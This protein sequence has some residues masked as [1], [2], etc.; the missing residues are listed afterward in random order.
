MNSRKLGP[1]PRPPA[2]GPTGEQARVASAA[3]AARLVD[4]ALEA[5]SETG[6]PLTREIA[7]WVVQAVV[8]DPLRGIYV[9]AEHPGP[10]GE[11]RGLAAVEAAAS[12]EH[13]WM[14]RIAMLYVRPPYRRQGLGAWLL[15]QTLELARYHGLNHLACDLVEG[16]E[17]A[18]RLLTAAGFEARPQTSYRIDLDPLYDDE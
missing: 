14:G 2:P 15:E 11:A 5:A 16:G 13:G 1:L 18:R 10:G 8:H 17:A 3:D 6:A 12:V 7:E 9:L 4:L